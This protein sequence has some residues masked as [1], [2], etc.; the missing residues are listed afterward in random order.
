MDITNSLTKQ[1]T[2]LA[3]LKPKLDIA[4][5][6]A[7]LGFDVFPLS[8]N[9]KT[10]VFEDSWKDLATHDTDRVRKLWAGGYRVCNVGLRTGLPFLNGLP[11]RQPSGGPFCTPGPR[12]RAICA[13][14]CIQ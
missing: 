1:R 11:C 2:P 5:G 3:N 12:V 7:E 13:S 10:P 8:P 4:L 9:R 6:L 14:V